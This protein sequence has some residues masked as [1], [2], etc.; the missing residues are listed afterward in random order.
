MEQSC[1]VCKKICVTLV[2]HNLTSQAH[3]PDGQQVS[4]KKC[5]FKQGHNAW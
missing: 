3:G 1:T 4:L 2:Y 5:H